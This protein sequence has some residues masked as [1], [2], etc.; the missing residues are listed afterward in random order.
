ML[1][2]KTRIAVG[3]LT[4]IGRVVDIGLDDRRVGAQLAARRDPGLAGLLDGALLDLRGQRRPQQRE[5]AAERGVGRNPIG[6]EAGEAPVQQVGAQ[7]P[8]QRAERPGLEV[9][10]HTAAQQPVGGD[11]HAAGAVG[12]GM[13]GRQA[14]T[15]EGN[16]LAIVQHGVDGIEEIVPQPGD[17]L[18]ERREE[19]L[20]LARQG[21][22]HGTSIA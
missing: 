14:L 11:A 15:H 1:R 19:Q 21:P 3:Q 13:A 4:A 7:L 10:E 5:G 22:Y 2:V 16:E 17:L 18:R 6:I 12:P 8:L 9:L 20:R